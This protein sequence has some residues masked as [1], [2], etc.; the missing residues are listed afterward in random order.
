MK[1]AIGSDHAGFDYKEK[2]KKY[3]IEAGHKIEDCGT[4]STESTDYPDYSHKVASLVE[5]KK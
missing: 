5:E 4:Y 3:L 2:I 1:L